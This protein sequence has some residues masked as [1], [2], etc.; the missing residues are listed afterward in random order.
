MTRDPEIVGDLIYEYEDDDRITHYLMSKVSFFHSIKQV[1]ESYQVNL[2]Q[3]FIHFGN[4]N[5]NFLF[6]KLKNAEKFIKQLKSFANKK[7]NRFGE[8]I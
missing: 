7:T 3:I 4:F 2:Y 5:E 8:T 6:R 1:N